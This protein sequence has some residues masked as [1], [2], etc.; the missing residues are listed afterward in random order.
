MDYNAILKMNTKQL[1]EWLINNFLIEIPTEIISIE[2]MQVASKLLMKLSNNYSY[3]CALSSY[4]KLATREA[5]RSGNKTEHENMV[6][7]KEIIQNM[8]DCIKQQYAA[9]SRAVT[10]HIENNAELR[11]NCAGIVRKE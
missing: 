4:A 3:L 5:K 1:L 2:D 7:R 11:M 10:I 6:D 8:T 9:V